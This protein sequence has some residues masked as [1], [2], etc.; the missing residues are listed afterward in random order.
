[1]KRID[2]QLD[3]DDSRRWKSHLAKSRDVAVRLFDDSREKERL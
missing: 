3:E 1:M 2:G